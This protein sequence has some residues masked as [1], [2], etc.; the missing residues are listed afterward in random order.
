MKRPSSFWKRSALAVGA[1]LAVF[2]VRSW[3]AGNGVGL[4]QDREASDWTR[5]SEQAPEA[6]A[7][8]EVDASQ[9]GIRWV[10]RFQ[11]RLRDPEADPSFFAEIFEDFE[12]AVQ[13]LAGLLAE[14]EVL[15]EIPDEAADPRSIASGLEL[16]EAVGQRMAALSLLEEMLL[17]PDAPEPAKRA[18]EQ[19]L[20]EIVTRHYGDVSSVGALTILLGEKARAIQVLV[21]RDLES[22]FRVYRQVEDPLLQAQ[23]KLQLR[24]ALLD[25][26]FSWPEARALLREGTESG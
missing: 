19:V 1:L 21:R 4:P 11:Q 20:A 22:A 26:G 5:T 6:T 7:I 14:R 24:S 16:P 15:A 8:A 25:A 18:V 13:G 3:L 12:R 2:C 10:T 9:V 17:H 23:L